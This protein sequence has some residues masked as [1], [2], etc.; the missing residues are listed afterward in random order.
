MIKKMDENYDAMDGWIVACLAC[1]VCC[2]G[3]IAFAPS[4]C[5]FSFGIYFLVTDYSVCGDMSPLWIYA[6][7]NIILLVFPHGPY[8]L[9][10]HQPARMALQKQLNPEQ[11]SAAFSPNFVTVDNRPPPLLLR[12]IFLRKRSSYSLLMCPCVVACGGCH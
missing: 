6:L 1:S 2:S 12:R 9:F 11:A 8:S 10:V 4:V 7:V 5:Y 3:C